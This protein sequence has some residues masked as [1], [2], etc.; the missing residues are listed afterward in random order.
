MAYVETVLMPN[1]KLHFKADIH[2]FVFVTSVTIILVGFFVRGIE[3]LL[4]LVIIGLG[5]FSLLKDLIYFLTTELAVT[6]RRV[7]AKFGWIMRNTVELNLSRVESLTVNQSIF[8]RMFNFGTL[9]INGVGGI[10]TPIPII[11][12]PLEFR[13]KTL[14]LL[15]AR[16]KELSYAA[17]QK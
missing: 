13:S 4:G 15:E 16:M 3:P 8:G 17:R 1:E 10:R 5:V 6:N 9:T 7:I 2:W 14:S 12:N 11:D